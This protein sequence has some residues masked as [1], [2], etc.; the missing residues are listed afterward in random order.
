MN[1]VAW[2]R[3]ITANKK[4]ARIVLCNSDDE[5]AFKVYRLTR[6]HPGIQDSSVPTGDTASPVPADRYEDVHPKELLDPADQL[7]PLTN[8]QLVTGNGV[9]C[10]RGNKPP[11]IKFETITEWVPADLAARLERE[12]AR[13]SRELAEVT[14]QRDVQ[15]DSRKRAEQRARDAEADAREL[16]EALVTSVN[17]N[18]PLR[19]SCSTVLE[20]HRMKYGREG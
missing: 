20:K 11:Q 4:P 3:Y 7:T 1:Y 14:A 15:W 6:T 5:G 8:S 19:Y 12:N 10:K 13:L 18:R 2:C 16:W 17:H 9:Y